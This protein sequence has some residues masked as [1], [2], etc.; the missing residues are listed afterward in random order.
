M[1][2]AVSNLIFPAFKH[3]DLLPALP[4]LGIG[5]VE[6]APAHTWLDP[7]DGVPSA[8]VRAYRKA[9]TP[10]GSRSRGCIACCPAGPTSACSTCPAWVAAPSST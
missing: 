8:E 7:W 2:L 3:H 5:G 4:A 1:K 9:A 10:P 6:V